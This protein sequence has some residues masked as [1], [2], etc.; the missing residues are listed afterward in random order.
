LQVSFKQREFFSYQDSSIR[1]SI[2]L[3]GAEKGRADGEKIFVAK[4]FAQA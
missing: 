4:S 3:D 1:S 2:L